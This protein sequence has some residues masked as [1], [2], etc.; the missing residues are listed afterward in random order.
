M[1]KTLSMAGGSIAPCTLYPIDVKI[2]IK[3]N[4]GTIL[5]A[6]IVKMACSAGD[7]AVNGMNLSIFNSFGGML[8]RAL[9]S[10]P[11]F[12]SITLEDLP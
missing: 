2:G 9:R 11:R 8:N 12:L 4:S 7:R 3:H 10:P 6:K 1:I 5:F